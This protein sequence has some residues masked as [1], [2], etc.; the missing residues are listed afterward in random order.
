MIEEKR[1]FLIAR[2]IKN[3]EYGNG[4]RGWQLGRFRIRQC[5]LATGKT[6]AS[7]EYI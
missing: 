5:L 6:I 7:Y 3:D 1:N 2:E 4:G